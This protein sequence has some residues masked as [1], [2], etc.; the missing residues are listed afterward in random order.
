MI[1]CQIC[2]KE[3]KLITNSHL[4]QHNISNAEEYKKLFPD[5]DTI[6]KTLKNKFK[7]RSKE[8]NK[9][10]IG[11][12]RSQ[13]V[14]NKISAKNKGNIAWN[15]GIKFDDTSIQQAAAKKREEKYQ[16]GIL[17][18][19]K[20]II[21]DEIKQRISKS[22]INYNKPKTEYYKKLNK[23][24]RKQALLN[25]IFN[26]IELIINYYKNAKQSNVEI[27]GSLK[28]HFIK[29]K[30]LKC[31]NKFERTIQALQDSKIRVDL[32]DNCRI[33]PKHSRHEIEI[34]NYIRGQLPEID[35][36]C[37]TRNMIYPLELDIYIPNLNL[38][39]EYCGLY[40]H[41]D[42]TGKTY[43]YHKKKYDLCK[44]KNIKL[45]TIFEDEYLHKK[46]I[47]LSRINNFLGLSDRIYAR[48]CLIKEIN[49]KD[50]NEFLNENH[51][52][53][54]GRSNIRL[55]L[56]YNNELI[57]LMTFNNS[58]ISRKNMEWEINRF[59]S[60]LGYNVIGGAN[61]LFKYFI[62]NYTPKNVISYA[63]LRWG[64]GKVYE[65]LGFKLEKITV[66]GY[67]YILGDK[68]IHRYSLKK[69]KFDNKNLT[70]VE[71]RTK[72]GYSRIW[73]CGHNKWVWNN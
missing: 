71:N 55:G 54:K 50:A 4:A 57:S 69:N 70:E 65:K 43:D 51:I 6:D 29:L 26:K 45:I 30:C 28:D 34:L 62:E 16:K 73:D 49:A 44:E 23:I 19:P 24:K 18:R 12:P 53:G 10:R 41:S 31:D 58:N 15:K 20:V 9:N 61:K 33:T 66:P 17:K 36:K 42:Q 13:E 27:L 60:K 22:L 37:G 64:D 7:A 63:D 32:C 68:R 47:V 56:F 48:K 39:I 40:W 2:Q 8:S 67:W 3:F 59:C 11:I 52:Q 25:V 14:K 72:Q 1:Q 38:A 21:T 35:I 46:E 5:F